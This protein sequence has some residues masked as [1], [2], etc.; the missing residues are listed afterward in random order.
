MILAIDMGNTNIKIGMISDREG[1]SIREERL[2]TDRN[3]TSMEYALMIT[4]ILDFYDISKRD[5]EGAIISSVVPPLTGVLDTAV[6]KVLGVEP[7]IVKGSMK[8]DISLE[9]F[10][11]PDILGADLI[12]GAEAAYKLYEPPVAVINMG[13][14]TTITVI[15]KEGRFEGGLI[16]PGLKT[17]IASLSQGTAQLPE[18][19][20][21]RPGAI[22]TVD[23]TESM[24]S[25]IIYGNAA[26]LDGLLGRLEQE[27]GESCTVVAT[28]GLSRFVIPYC[29]HKVIMDDK[30]LMK[31]LLMLY[32]ENRAS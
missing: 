6:R 29:S 31:G 17:S 24:R 2:M 13:T 23:T 11:I 27:L 16:L 3:K 14:A 7:L 9:K 19:D 5:F 8:L 20:L 15:S 28:G 32:N 22:I 18:I 1:S 26:Q 30:L 21:S 4:S 25:G 12:I 10:P